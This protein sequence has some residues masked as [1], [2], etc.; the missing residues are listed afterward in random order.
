M[1]NSDE[2]EGRNT[3]KFG[4][5]VH[6]RKNKNKNQREKK[7][8]TVKEDRLSNLP[9]EVIHSIL[10][11]VD[12][13]TAVQTS[14]LSKRWKQLWTSVPVLNLHDDYFDDP[15]V[16]Q[17][18]VEQFLANRD[19][20]AKVQGLSFACQA[21]LNDGNMVDSIIDYVIQTPVS[22]N[23]KFISILAECVI[24]KLP[25]LS[26]CQSLTTLKLVDIATE[27]TTFDFVSLEK[28]YLCDCRF[29][30]G[31]EFLDPFRGCANLKCLFMHGCQYYGDIEE[32]IISAPQLTELSISSMRVDEVFDS[33]CVIELFTPKLRS[34]SYS[35]SDL[36][37]FSPM[38]DLSFVEKVDIVLECLTTDADLCYQLIDLFEAMGSAK[39]VSLSP[40]I[41][42]VLSMFPALLDGR[43]SPFTGVQSFELNMD[44]PSFFAIPTNVMAYLFG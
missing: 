11:F 13:T 38:V 18:F 15:F 16:F 8:I 43:S 36:Y 7:K 44:T 30:C 10:S 37:D 29:E 40:G 21:E 34:F 33:D 19:A 3:F 4:R 6:G 5:E 9:D 26:L 41:I 14:V 23:I 22:T 39:F 27:T 2:V 20:S 12:A 24:R 32:L 42:E 25:Q 1:K 35:D 17:C 28:L 31:E